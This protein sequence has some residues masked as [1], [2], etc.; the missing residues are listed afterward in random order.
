MTSTTLPEGVGRAFV[1]TLRET[2]LGAADALG[3][4]D[5]RAGDR[6]RQTCALP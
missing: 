2:L 5:R 1:T 6:L 3:D 4:L